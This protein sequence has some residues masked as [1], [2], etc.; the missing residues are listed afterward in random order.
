[1]NTR[2]YLGT[3]TLTGNIRHLQMESQSQREAGSL[4]GSV[5]SDL[6]V[7]LGRS[8]RKASTGIIIDRVGISVN[9][10]PVNPIDLRASTLMGKQEDPTEV[11]TTAIKAIV[12]FIIVVVAAVKSRGGGAPRN[13]DTEVR[14]NLGTGVLRNP[15]GGALHA[16]EESLNHE[17][18]INMGNQ[19][20][21]GRLP[22]PRLCQSLREERVRR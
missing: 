5:E 22:P 18:P 10:P 21:P 19:A 15:V 12:I 17:S 13:P 8:R 11:T 9:G 20:P 16:P 1:M 14:Q 4:E 6:C 3:Q 2:R 7:T